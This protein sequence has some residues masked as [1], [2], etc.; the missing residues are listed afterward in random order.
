MSEVSGS[1]NDKSATVFMM[2]TPLSE[3]DNRNIPPASESHLFIEFVNGRKEFVAL[4]DGGAQINVVSEG[5]L[6]ELSYQN[7]WGPFTSM[8]WGDG[9][10]CGV[11]GWIL[12]PITLSNSRKTWVR[13][14]VVCGIQKTLI[15]GRPFLKECGAQVCHASAV[16]TTPEGPIPLLEGYN[17]NSNVNNVYADASSP[18]KNETGQPPVPYSSINCL[19]T[20]FPSALKDVFDSLSTG[21]QEK[22]LKKTLCPSLNHRQKLR[23]QNLL[24]KSVK[25]WGGETIGAATVGSHNIDLLHNH[26][27]V[28]RP[29][30][31]TEE[32]NREIV[33]EIRQMLKD[34]IIRPSKSPY[35]SELVLVK[36]PNGKWR[37][38]VDFR[39]LN[40]ATVPDKYPLPRLADLLKSVKNSKH[41]IALDQRWGYWQIPLE[42]SSCQYTAFRC[43]AGLFEFIRM[44]F[45]L[46]SAP[47]T[48][49]RI[50]D[51]LFGDLRFDGVLVYLDDILL[52]GATVDEVLDRLEV[53]LP[54]ME[55]AGLHLNL[56]KCDF[57]PECLKYLGHVFRDGCMFPNPKKV[58]TLRNI[59]RPE[60]VGET[61]SLMG[62]LNYYH[63]YISHFAEIV[64][65]INH[66]LRGCVKK[67]DPTPIEWTEAHDLSIKIIKESLAEAC[68]A[69]PIDSDE[70]LLETDASDHGIAA[71][72]SIKRDGK[73]CPVEFSSKKFSDT[74]RRWPV[75]EKE[76]YAIIHGLQKFDYLLRGRQFTVHTDH[77]SLQ[78]IMDAKV[79]KLARWA[80]LLAE[81]DMTVLWK[82]G[83]QL[84]HIDYFSRYAE[85]PDPVLDHMVYTICAPPSKS[86]QKNFEFPTV[87][88]VI[89]AQKLCALPSGSR[90]T[91][92]NGALY[93]IGG[94]WVPESLRQRVI[95]ACHLITPIHHPKVTKT[96]KLIKKAFNWPNI[97]ADVFDFVKSCLSC[98]RFGFGSEHRQGLFRTHPVPGPFNS[99]YVDYWSATYHNTQYSVITMIDQHTKWAEATPVFDHT[100]EVA[101][102]TFLTSW[103]TRFGVPRIVVHDGEGSF[104][105][106]V[107]NRLVKRLGCHP[108]QITPHHPEG[109]SPIES[110]HR[111]L[112]RGLTDFNSSSSKLPFNEALQLI[113][114]AYRSTVHSSTHETPA[115]LTYGT[116]L[117][118][119]LEG[120]WRFATSVEEKDRIKFLNI[121]RL[122]LQYQVY[123]RRIAANMKSNDGRQDIGFSIND[124]VLCRTQSFKKNE[125]RHQ[126]FPSGKKLVPSWGLPCRVIK[127][128]PGRKSAYVR[129][130]L[131]GRDRHVHLQDARFLQ[132]PKCSEMTQSWNQQI[133]GEMDSMFNPARRREV[134]EK[135]WEEVHFPQVDEVPSPPRIQKRRRTTSLKGRVKDFTRETGCSL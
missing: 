78:W 112:R 99:V 13:A 117:R 63:G 47:A 77:Q 96:E 35:A 59:K 90:F 17:V 2:H 92:R 30:R 89:A 84:Q 23:L 130:L 115:F 122:D 24:L 114:M 134:L 97:H 123:K 107:F 67:K 39:A 79:G 72:V 57:F 131:S 68:L 32:Q 120:D 36:K 132:P 58:E 87:E 126:E 106:D 70:F 66:L 29:R 33:E 6:H 124:L 88:E 10:P 93:Y 111:Y 104:I 121:L 7:C 45:G 52:H 105:S 55:A 80:C 43:S 116:D 37:V 38:C 103:I 101:A 27:V 56:D 3:T 34:G 26:P 64:A 119:P 21:D 5:L 8:R 14:A 12:L 19:P 48:F 73:W 4:I 95:A 65:P 74:Q 16:L 127:V 82:S 75:R 113:L 50:M 118:S 60:S 109:N 40:K 18:E 102:S 129:S 100:K 71:V 128:L 61:R 9:N 86:L 49:Q 69:I 133:E 42:K 25:I 83:K 20:S 62:M 54:R 81:Y 85:D 28:V 46:V 44:P 22:F 76:A 53:V 11:R 108:I 51:N 91:F 15:F 135:F 94:L 98:Q 41:F 1:L 125:A 110:F 31:Y